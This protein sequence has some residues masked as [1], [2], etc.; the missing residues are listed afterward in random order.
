MG[1]EGHLR[2][3]FRR[4]FRLRFGCWSAATIRG[5]VRRLIC[6]SYV[7]CFM[8]GRYMW[9][10][11]Y[12]LSDFCADSGCCRCMS[13]APSVSVAMSPRDGA[14]RA[15]PAISGNAR[16]RIERAGL[17]LGFGVD[18]EDANTGANPASGTRPRAAETYDMHDRARCVQSAGMCAQRAWHASRRPPG[19]QE[20]SGWERPPG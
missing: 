18:V 3:V 19:W 2:E 16:G 10:S 14:A 11:L 6:V 12:R 20:L 1:Y 5:V 15:R 9:C 8:Y 13:A 17:G 7:R 4:F